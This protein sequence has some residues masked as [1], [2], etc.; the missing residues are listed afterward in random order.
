MTSKLAWPTLNSHR[1][2]SSGWTRDHRQ[3]RAANHAKTPVPMYQAP[4]V[5]ARN[6]ETRQGKWSAAHG[7]RTNSTVPS[8]TNSTETANVAFRV[9]GPSTDEP[10]HPGERRATRGPRRALADR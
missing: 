1:Y 9:A 3:S 5:M 8:A 7:G 4:I 10:C 2:A 6:D